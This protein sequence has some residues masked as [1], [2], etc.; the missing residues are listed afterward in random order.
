MTPQTATPRLSRGL[1]WLRTPVGR[2][3]LLLIVATAATG[4]AMAAQQNIVANYFEGVLGLDGAQFGYITA[5]REIPGF[6]LIFLTALFYRLSL[7]RLTALALLVLAVGYGLYGWSN[8]FWTVA[9]WVIISSMGYHTWLQTQYALGMSL[10][11]EARSGGILGRLSAINSAGGLAAMVVVLVGF[12]Q[13]WLDFRLTFVVCGVL[14]LIAAVAI[15]GFPHVHNGEVQAAAARRQPIVWRKEYR[16]YYLLNLLDGGRQQ[17]FFSFGLWVLVH[18]FALDVP[19]V[20][21]ILLTV[22]CLSMV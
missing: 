15:F 14:A 19:T 16:Y 1:A 10:T 13:G 5:I 20:S 8:S 11:T 2:G 6:L 18:H 17:I 7:P 4:F 22:T 12:G 3:F 21:A 9:P